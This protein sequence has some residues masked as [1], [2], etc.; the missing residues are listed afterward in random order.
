[1]KPSTLI[2]LCTVAVVGSLSGVFLNNSRA[3][4]ISCSNVYPFSIPGS[5]RTSPKVVPE[6]RI[7]LKY[8][9]LAQSVCI[10]DL[11]RFAKTGQTTP[12][13]GMILGAAK[14]KPD[15]V[16]GLMTLEVGMNILGLGN[17]LYSQNGEAV[18]SAIAKTV[19]TRSGPESVKALRGAMMNAAADGKVSLLEVLQSYPTWQMD[20]E[21]SSLASTIEQ[22]KGLAGNLP[23]LK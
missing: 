8:G 2:S 5:A 18:L 14:M 21:L 20:V 3:M 16:R 22:I 23:S 4:A 12:T 17:F 1:M 9:A 19:Q 10:S 6:K 13:L 7:T 15:Q 11:E